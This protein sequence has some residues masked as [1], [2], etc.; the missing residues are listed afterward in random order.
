M[1]MLE[2]LAERLAG[3]LLAIGALLLMLVLFLVKLL[4]PGPESLA[5]QLTN[6]INTQMPTLYFGPTATP[7]R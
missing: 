5:P 1:E 6:I 2:V 7:H 4:S 3:K